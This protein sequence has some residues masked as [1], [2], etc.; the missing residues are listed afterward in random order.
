M[1]YSRSLS[2]WNISD[3]NLLFMI[4]VVV[5]LNSGQQYFHLLMVPCLSL[6]PVVLWIRKKQICDPG[7][8]AADVPLISRA[9]PGCVRAEFLRGG[10]HQRHLPGSPRN[11]SSFLFRVSTGSTA[12]FPR[13]V[14]S[15]CCCLTVNVFL[16]LLPR[17]R[18]DR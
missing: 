14:Y 18:G 11:S 13:F 17:M 5:T 8:F 7:H 16:W 2:A 1:T 6:A 3:E 4:A 12:E 15:W 9:S 10:N